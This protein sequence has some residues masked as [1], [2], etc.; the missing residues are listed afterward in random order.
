MSA[1]IKPFMM[2]TMPTVIILLAAML[3]ANNEYDKNRQ[4]LHSIENVRWTGGL[5]LY[6][7]MLLF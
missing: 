2:I 3:A 4:A 5:F 6:L 1:T 7:I